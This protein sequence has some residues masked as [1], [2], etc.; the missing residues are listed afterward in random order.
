[1]ESSA[2]SLP[3]SLSKTLKDAQEEEEEERGVQV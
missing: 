2:S 3:S 1:L